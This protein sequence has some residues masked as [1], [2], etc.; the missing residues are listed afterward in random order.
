[1]AKRK[2]YE[3]KFPA[4]TKVRARKPGN[5][6]RSVGT[7]ICNFYFGQVTCV[8]VR[9]PKGGKWIYDEEFVVPAP[10]QAEKI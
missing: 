3:P 6:R 5:A 4:G 10:A 2:K 9:F 7:V 8:E 1:M